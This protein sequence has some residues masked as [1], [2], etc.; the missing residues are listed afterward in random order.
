MFAG[1][2]KTGDRR[3]V[4]R[5]NICKCFLGILAIALILQSV[6][7]IINLGF[8]LWGNPDKI[9]AI[10][11]DGSV[12]IQAVFGYLH[13]SAQEL[14]G[15]RAHVNDSVLGAVITAI[16]L[17]AE[18]IPLFFILWKSV[19]IFRKMV[20]LNSP[21]Y[22]EICRHIRGIGCAIIYLGLFQKLIMQVG[23]SCIAYHKLWFNNPFNLVLVFVG[24]VVLLVGDI[25]T[26]GCELQKESDELL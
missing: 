1:T 3:M 13:L 12:K 17:C 21:F 2:M 20:R 25:F 22:G 10:Y 19:Q 8:F 5:V 26:Y 9:H 4:Y 11:R 7:L 16:A 23:V 24:I 14:P 6:A 18:K 15:G